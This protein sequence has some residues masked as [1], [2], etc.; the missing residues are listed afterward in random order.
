VDS[1][2][3]EKYVDGQTQIH[4]TL[5]NPDGSEM[6]FIMD[7]QKDY[8]VTSCLITGHG[9]AVISKRYSD[10]QSI[11]GNWVP[12]AVLLERYEAESNRLLARDLWNITS[13]DVNTPES[14]DFEVGYEDDA[15]IEH[16]SF[17]GSR[18][19]MYRYLQRV[20][21]DLLL[22]ERL[23]YIAS[24]NA[25]SQNCATAAL[26]Y[27]ASQLGKNITDQQL[28]QLVN[29]P[30]KT[31][32]LYQIK[33]FAQGLGLYCRAVK[34]D[35]KTLKSLYGC[36]VI[37]HIPG[38]KH[39]VVLEAIDDKYVWTV[40]LASNKFYYRT[41]INFFEMDWTDGI[42]L[43]ISNSP[44]AGEFTEI[45]ES[46]LGNITG[47]SGYQ[48]NILRQEYNVIFCDYIG[49]ECG[50]EYKVFFTR[51]GCGP[52]ES[53]SCSQTKMVRYKKSPCILDPYDLYNCDVT[54]E[55]TVYYMQACA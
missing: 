16:F 25:Q 14:Y 7:Q 10:Y 37:L 8:A 30:D 34:T 17:S 39:F 51:W 50:G 53:G 54:G 33:Q 24:E 46:E 55:W 2:A 27:V 41:D 21:P 29:G 19:E 15:L 31:T 13:I 26:K 48:C 43:L 9:N 49:G 6:L 18:P 44:I 45:D 36:K 1:S 28:A 12:S 11:A 38:K 23:A 40:D 52:A 35:I 47:A 42:A 5:N 3:V 32:N 22:A 4:L 20:N